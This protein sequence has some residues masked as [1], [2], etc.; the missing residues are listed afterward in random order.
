MN[1]SRS[2]KGIICVGKTFPPRR[3]QFS[4]Y[5]FQF[6]TGEMFSHRLA[7]KISETHHQINNYFEFETKINVFDGVFIFTLER[8]TEGHL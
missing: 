7:N 8:G 3:K 2:G 5:F 1:H 6:T 4:L